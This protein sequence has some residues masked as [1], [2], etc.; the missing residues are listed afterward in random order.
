M[1]AHVARNPVGT[2]GQPTGRWWA[3]PSP[4]AGSPT[5][6]LA[7]WA[8]VGRPAQPINSCRP[9]GPG[10]LSVS[11]A[12]GSPNPVWAAQWAPCPIAILSCIAQQ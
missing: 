4:P 3:S 2:H 1:G 6:G 5:G 12:N 7:R 10:H 11:P 8:P 9:L